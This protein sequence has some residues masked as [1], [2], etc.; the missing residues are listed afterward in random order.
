MLSKIWIRHTNLAMNYKTGPVIHVILLF[1]LSRCPSCSHTP[2]CRTGDISLTSFLLW[3][4]LMCFN[5]TNIPCSLLSSSINLKV[6][7]SVSLKCS[8]V[9]LLYVSH[10]DSNI[11]VQGPD[12]ISG[13]SGLYD[14]STVRVN[15]FLVST[16]NNIRQAEKGCLVFRQLCFCPLIFK[17]IMNSIV[18]MG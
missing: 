12:P 1:T 2:S 17:I 13:W 15:A 6:I 9:Y 18:I 5:S 8:T 11:L 10:I 3:Q 7:F 16:I 4:M 14:W